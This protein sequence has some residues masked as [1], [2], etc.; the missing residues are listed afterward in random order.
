MH[1]I[2]LY[3]QNGA[4]IVTIHSVTSLHPTY[5]LQCGLKRKHL[6]A[7]KY[8]IGLQLLS[9]GLFIDVLRKYTFFRNHGNC[10]KNFHY[11]NF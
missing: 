6:V 5:P 9:G 11:K 7:D 2:M 10:L 1:C 3:P 4:H 8:Q